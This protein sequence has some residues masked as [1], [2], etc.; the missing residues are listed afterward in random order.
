MKLVSCI[1]CI[2]PTSM[3]TKSTNTQNKRITINLRKLP[4]REIP[5]IGAPLDKLPLSKLPTNLSI[6]RRMR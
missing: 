6:L 5:Y 3:K 2:K 1:E 4:R